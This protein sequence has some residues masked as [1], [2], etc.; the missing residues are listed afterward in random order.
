VATAEPLP[1]EETRVQ[2]MHT[3]SY[4]FGAPDLWPLTRQ[5]VLTLAPKMEQAGHRDDWLI[6]LEQATALSEEQADWAA[7]A[8]CTLQRGMLH[9]LLSQF[10]LAIER[11]QRSIALCQ[12]IGAGRDQAR[13]LNELA[14][15]AY[16]QHQTAAATS[17]V[18]QALALL[19]E[20]DPERA[21][22]YRVQGMIAIAHERWGEAEVYHRQALAIFAT[23]G[24]DRKAA[25]SLQNLAYALCGQQRFDEAI[26]YYEEAAKILRELSDRYNLAVVFFNLGI[27]WYQ[28]GAVDRAIVYYVDACTAFKE[29]NNK[30]FLARIH[31]DLGLALL[32][33]S[34]YGEAEAAFLTSIQFFTEISDDAWRLNAMDGLAML[35]LTQQAYTKA[36][37]VLENALCALPQISG[38]TNYDYLHHSLTAHLQDALAKQRS[39]G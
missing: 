33:C 30:L 16:L 21:M 6:Y 4:A 8:E 26:G 23:Q 36:I 2:A 31:T 15:V 18:E 38:A 10:P 22:C 27:A 35:Y 1:D 12:Q 37:E 5:L 24:D 28:L 3:L 20:D 13:A 34:R 7:A 14:W 25:W 32:A 29:L 9:R 11:L 19:T 39:T 17:Y